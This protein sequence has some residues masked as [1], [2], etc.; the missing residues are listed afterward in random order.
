[1]SHIPYPKL[2]DGVRQNL[3]LEIYS[4]KLEFWFGNDE[5]HEVQIE[6]R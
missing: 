6:L 3:V 2:D 4:K 5:V 1:M